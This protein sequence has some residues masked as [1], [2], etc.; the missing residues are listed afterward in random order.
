MS[1]A[2]LTAQDQLTRYA[3]VAWRP[4]ELIEVRCLPAMRDGD[5]APVSFWTKAEDLPARRERLEALNVQSMNVYAGILPRAKE[6]G[7]SDA[8]CAGGFAVWQD[9]DGADPRAAWK[10]ATAAG[11]PAPSMVINSGHG[12]HLIWAL[13]ERTD[14]AAISALVGDMAALLGSDS[15]VRN[16]SRIL[17]LPG[18]VNW[19]APVADAVLMFADPDRRYAFDALRAAVPV[20]KRQ[21]TPARGPDAPEGPAQGPATRLERA[22]RYVA[23]IEGSGKGGRTGKAFKVAAVLVNDYGLSEPDALTILAGWDRAANSPPIVQDYGP[24][25]LPKI[26]QNAR[27]YA[28]HPAGEKADAPQR[29]TG[30]FVR[31]GIAPRRDSR[32][33]RG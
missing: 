6:G 32:R 26:L 20:P 25:E 18:F 17:R 24:G 12:A 8:D 31:P 15:S 28:K 22:R 5:G 19:K 3:A 21:E 30:A 9:F 11:L 14:A 7:K 13:A 2:T 1:T 10:T 29:G 16:P 23:T 4:G 27:R 33:N